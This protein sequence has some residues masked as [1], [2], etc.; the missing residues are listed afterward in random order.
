MPRITAA[1]SRLHFRTRNTTSS[2]RSFW[3]LKKH[4]PAWYPPIHRR[5]GSQ[6]IFTKGFPKVTHDVPMMSH[7]KT[8]MRR[9]SAS[10]GWPAWGGCYRGEK[11]RFYR[12]GQSGRRRGG[13][14]GTTTDR[15]K[16]EL[17]RGDGTTATIVTRQFRTI[18]RSPCPLI[19]G[20]R[21][22][23]AGSVH[24][25]RPFPAPQRVHRRER[26]NGHAE[27]PPTPRRGPSSSS[28]RK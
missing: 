19:T 14:S 10:T 1:G 16:W 4:T 20:G 28:T 25:L 12:R 8:P 26:S 7:R 11:N 9:R 5:K 3:T 24:D 22:K 2:T 27:S 18:R 17:R 23:S 6:A 13:A 21:L 15:L